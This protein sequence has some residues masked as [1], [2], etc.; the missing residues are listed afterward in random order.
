MS[1]P[2]K[3][4]ERYFRVYCP[5]HKVSFTVSEAG[6]IVC[7]GGGEA[8]AQKFP[9]EQAWEYCCDCQSLWPSDLAKGG[10]AAE[11]CF[12]CGREIRRRYVCDN[13]KVIS[14]D[15]DG[16]TKRKPFSIPERI[17]EPECPGCSKNSTGVAALEHRCAEAGVLF[18]TAHASCPFCDEQIANRPSFPAPVAEYLSRVRDKKITCKLDLQDNLLVA[19]DDGKFVLL[20]SG[21]T[22]NLSIVLPKLTRFA[23]KRDY[24]DSYEDYYECET[25][26]AG[27][28]IVIYPAIATKLENGWKLKEI[29]RL[30]IKRDPGHTEEPIIEVSTDTDQAK[31]VCP[32]CN[33]PGQAED[34]FCKECGFQ[35]RS[36]ERAANWSEQSANTASQQDATSPVGVSRTPHKSLRIVLILAVCVAAILT[37][38]AIT[39][40]SGGGGGSAGGSSSSGASTESKLESA[41]AKR[42]LIAPQGES[43]YDYYQQL[44]REGASKSTLSKFDAQLLPL[45]TTG[46][47]QM[48]ANFA[49][50]GG[51]DAPRA[52]WDEAGKLLSWAR[53]LKPGD[54]ALAARSD[55]CNARAAFLDNRI[56][57]ALS[58]LKSA[59]DLDTSWGLP[60][61][62]LGFIYYK[63]LK[64]NEQAREYFD[65]AIEREQNWAVPHL[66]KGA[67]YYVDGNYEQANLNYEEAVRLAPDWAHAHAALGNLAKIRG[68]QAWQQQDMARA[69]EEFLTAKRELE[70]ALELA[71]SNFKR[72]G[73]DDDLHDVRIRLGQ[74]NY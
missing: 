10:K 13:C 60:A 35:I 51:S 54:N 11:Q 50:P 47:E 12:V 40:L 23:S 72:K 17:V 57:E 62:D 8:L 14:L 6:R 68:E 58:L 45:L 19:D 52:E 71:P 46:S 44:K 21:T 15:S 9:Y 7:E 55:Y 20:P 42:N 30:D 70:R 48:I 74:L 29:G 63:N 31:D 3:F 65:A 26:A 24:Y 28:V 69:R 61:Q 73:V 38:A 37:I 27:E 67:T 43:A 25:P 56:N 64:D 41:I 53:A 5:T 39:R 66:Y 4:E 36:P 33:T 34:I 22:P 49:A 18:S 32:H 1:M 16:P 59:H 2:A